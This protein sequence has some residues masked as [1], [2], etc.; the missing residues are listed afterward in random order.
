MTLITFP[1]ALGIKHIEWSLDQPAQVNRSQFTGR[2]QVT[3][4][5]L[6]PR[7][8]AHVEFAPIIGEAA[9]LAWR[10]FMV[11]L[12][13][14]ANTFHLKAVENTQR[15][16]ANPLAGTAAAGAI[17]LPLTGLTPS[18]TN[19][20]TG[21]MLSVPL[22]T[23]DTQL[24]ILTQDL[25]ADGSGNATAHFLGCLRAPAASGQAVEAGAPFGVMA[26][27]G[28]AA[29]YTVDPGQIYGAAFE[30]EEAY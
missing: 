1:T 25:I 13:G 21:R 8:S 9:V 24:V 11:Q 14:P 3:V 6:S 19:L 16:A 7:W 10:A 5:S 18:T 30:A 17:T 20:L 4:L 26:L 2:R 28:T 29:G 27:K 12:Q 22:S 15:A 23:G